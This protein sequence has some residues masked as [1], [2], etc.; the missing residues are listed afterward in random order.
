MNNRI[1]R[2]AAYLMIIII[3]LFFISG[4]YAQSQ[5]K[6]EQNYQISN[7]SIV[8]QQIMIS[9]SKNLFYGIFDWVTVDSKN[10]VVTLK[11]WVHLP[12]LKDQLQEAAEKV[13][14]VKS[15]DNKIEKTIEVGGIG[16]Q[17]AHVIYSSDQ[18]YFV[19]KYS[20]NPP[21]HIISNS[22]TVIL[23]GWVESKR[24]KDMAEYLVILFTNAVSVKNELKVLPRGI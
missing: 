20:K 16:G 19:R 17:A 4:A 21:V 18:W 2:S 9:F 13:P 23:E 11:G 24:L 5:N 7:D 15:I 12:W 10:G 3:T 6:G 14:G 22:G 1:D 8:T